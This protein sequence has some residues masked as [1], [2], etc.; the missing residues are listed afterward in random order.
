MGAQSF[1][2]DGQT[3]KHDEANGH[4]SQFC[5]LNR[6]QENV[7]RRTAVRFERNG[8]RRENSL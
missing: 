2:A 7:L 3:D 6:F 1:H 8:S 4:F 5:E